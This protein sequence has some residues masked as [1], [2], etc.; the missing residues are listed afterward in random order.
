M[1]L[2]RWRGFEIAFKLTQLL[3]DIILQGICHFKILSTD[4]E[5]HGY[6][7]FEFPLSI[8]HLLVY[9]K[10][11]LQFEGKRLRLP[12]GTVRLPRNISL[13]IRILYFM[14]FKTKKT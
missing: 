9:F 4:V 10:K 11:H 6:S 2:R 12:F 7:S 3:F 8:T 13:K 5:F 1:Y 14:I